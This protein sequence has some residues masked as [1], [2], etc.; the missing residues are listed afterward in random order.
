MLCCSE[1]YYECVFAMCRV[2][3]DVGLGCWEEAGEGGWGE[4]I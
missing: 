2:V 3:V 1:M 4:Y